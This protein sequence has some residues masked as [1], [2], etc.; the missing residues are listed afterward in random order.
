MNDKQFRFIVTYLFNI[1]ILVMCVATLQIGQML[2]GGDATILFATG[3]LTFLTMRVI[4]YLL[5]KAG[6]FKREDS[7]HED[8]QERV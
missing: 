1:F 7:H 8:R 6:V 3:V 4:V 2:Y 5:H